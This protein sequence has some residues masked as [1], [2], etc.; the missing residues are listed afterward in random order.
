MAVYDFLHLKKHLFQ[1]YNLNSNIVISNLLSIS[2]FKFYAFFLLFFINFM[3][4]LMWPLTHTFCSF[5][6]FQIF[7]IKK[8]KEKKAKKQHSLLKIYVTSKCNYFLS[9]LYK[10]KLSDRVDTELRR[11]NGSVWLSTFKKKTIIST[12]KFEFRYCYF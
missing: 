2:K 9:D 12:I 1:H 3:R 10:K 11:R 4:L 8:K 5:L 7:L 6:F